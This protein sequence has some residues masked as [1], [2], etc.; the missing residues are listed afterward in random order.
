MESGEI[1]VS[2]NGDY[3]VKRESLSSQPV[4]FSTLDLY[5][6]L[7]GTK[8]P[9]R[10]IKDLRFYSTTPGELPSYHSWNDSLISDSNHGVVRPMNALQLSSQSPGTQTELI[11]Q[12]IEEQR[13]QADE[14]AAKDPTNKLRRKPGIKPTNAHWLEVYR[15]FEETLD[16]SNWKGEPHVPLLRIIDDEFLEPQK[17][18]LIPAAD[19]SFRAMLQE[20]NSKKYA[21]ALKTSFIGYAD[22]TVSKFAML[23]FGLPIEPLTYENAMHAGTPEDKPK[24]EGEDAEDNGMTVQRITY[25]EKPLDF[26]AYYDERS[27]GYPMIRSMLLLML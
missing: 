8:H 13:A 19:N 12:L 18:L 16:K 14:E 4:T 23:R 9:R 10:N 25:A 5:T 7:P 11:A 15:H 27:H 20:E 2:L 3:T 22:N 26:L 21:L 6:G 17:L 1:E 24:Q